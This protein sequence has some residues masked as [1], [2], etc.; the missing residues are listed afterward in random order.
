MVEIN[1]NEIKLEIISYLYSYDSYNED[2]LTKLRENINK[3]AGNV[4]FE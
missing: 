3:Y 1:L 2:N 4:Y